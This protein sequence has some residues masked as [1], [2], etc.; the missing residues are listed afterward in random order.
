[1]IL[2][3]LLPLL[4]ANMVTGAFNIL[5]FTPQQ[6]F[7]LLILSL[8]GAAINI[9]LK[10]WPAV[11][12]NKKD[13]DS[14]PFSNLN[15]ILVPDK[16]VLAINL[17]GAILPGL[18]SLWLILR[19]INKYPAYFPLFIMVLILN[20]AVSYKISKPVPGKGI[21]VP[22]FIPP[23]VVSIPSLLF[24]QEIAPIIAFPAGVLGV[25]IGADLL[26]LKDI[27]G[28][29]GPVM[30]SIGGAG[31][32]DGIFLCGILSVFLTG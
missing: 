4:F 10:K 30:V 15:S 31:T 16:K 13:T 9:P 19:I 12:K 25:I 1:M 28:L 6:A 3:F 14:S 24:A 17:G 32:F 23:L 8:L 11:Y 22:L 21:A 7:S 5:G 18:I 26:H 29:D 27:T 20:I 2:L